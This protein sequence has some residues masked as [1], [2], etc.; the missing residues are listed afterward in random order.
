VGS[1]TSVGHGSEKTQKYINTLKNGLTSAQN[2]GIM[3]DII[4]NKKIKSKYYNGKLSLFDITVER[5]DKIPLIKFNTLSQENSR[6]LQQ[7]GKDLLNYMQKDK[8]GLEGLITYDM[9]M[10]EIE[11]HK[12]NS[13][14]LSVSIPRYNY[15]CIVIHN[16]PSGLIFSPKD[17]E[18]FSFNDE[19]RILGA[20]GNNGS[21]YYIEK[22]DDF[23]SM[24]FD[25][26][27][28]KIK[29]KHGYTNS[30]GE[31]KYNTQDDM[32]K[33]IEEL[34]EEGEECGFKTYISTY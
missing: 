15:N 29:N 7:A 9:S 14:N 5:I 20:I 4:S 26:I 33:F 23:D 19:I 17:L 30:S 24:Q 16:H 18:I 10:K 13:K 6:K 21:V 31:Y 2:D 32:F 1:K 3:N 22:T 27:Y 34:L 28:W 12:G 11:R 25:Y 8:T